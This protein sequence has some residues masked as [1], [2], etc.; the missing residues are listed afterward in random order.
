MLRPSDFFDLSGPQV[1]R[2]FDGIELVWEV[3]PRIAAIMDDLVQDQRRIDGAVSPS[4][5]LGDARIVIEDGAV[6][7]PGAYIVGPAYIGRGA[8]VRHGAYLRPYCIL[9]EGAIVGHASEMKSSILL[10]GAQAPHFAYI[11]DSILGNRVNLG[12][13]TRLSNVPVT[14]GYVNGVKEKKSIHLQIDGQDYDT[15]TRKLGAIL[16]DEVHTGCNAVLNPGTLIGKRSLVYPNMTI[17]KGFY[18]ADTIFKL[19]QVV[20]V[21]ERRY[22][23]PA[24]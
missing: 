2:V 7:E 11:G 6:V 23:Q 21:V 10:P 14:A 24:V 1:A 5:A 19:R 3:I 13:G 17:P 18:P 15:G 12:A 20:E 4:V 22:S 9:L 16:G 8:T